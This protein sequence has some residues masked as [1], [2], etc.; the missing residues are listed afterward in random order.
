[1]QPRK[2]P[3]FRV[4]SQIPQNDRFM[5]KQQIAG[6]FDKNYL[7]FNN[8]PMLYRNANGIPREIVMQTAQR[9][10]D[11]HGM[12][13]AEIAGLLGCSQAT[14]SLW[15]KEVRQQQFPGDQAAVEFFTRSIVEEQAT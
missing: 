3:S 8:L 9:L 2:P 1:M 5:C 14:V 10:R 12:K 15:L 13:Q 4:V 6:V 7:I 11:Q